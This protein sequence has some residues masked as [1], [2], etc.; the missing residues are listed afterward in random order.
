MQ[1]EVS[2]VDW[3][4]R[5]LSHAIEPVDVEFS[6]PLW[7][8][9]S[10]GTTGMPKGIVHGHG[11]ALLEQ[12][13]LGPSTPTSAPGTAYLTV[14]STSWVVWNGLVAAL[15]VG[16]TAVLVDGNPTFRSLDRIWKIASDERVAVLGVGAGFIHACAK[17]GAGA[18]AR[19]R[20]VGDARDHGHGI[21]AVGRRIPL[22]LPQRRGCLAHV[23]ERRHRHRVDLRRRRPDAA[24]PS[25]VHPG[26]GARRP[27]RV[28]GRAGRSHARTRESSSSQHRCP[29]CRCILG[30]RRRLALPASYFETI[31]AVWRHG[32]SSS[33]SSGGS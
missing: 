2:A 20:P 15:G 28:L 13:K 11:G 24:G 17:A 22:G 32:T 19:S 27:G 10:S 5:S 33:S 30:R 14:A 25:R 1:L 31:P 9:F 12:L 18:R 23:A 21:A 3:A 16:A 6:H 8:L 7:V 26:P 4:T 29:R